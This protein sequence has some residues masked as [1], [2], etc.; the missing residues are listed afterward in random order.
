[1]PGLDEILPLIRLLGLPAT[2]PQ[3]QA[4]AEQNRAMYEGAGL[5]PQQAQT[6]FPDALFHGHVPGTGLPVLGGILRGVGQTGQLLQYI[7]GDAPTAPRP[8]EQLSQM[9]LINNMQR[10]AR[11]DKA[12]QDFEEKH[13]E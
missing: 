9:M 5:T 7:L 1:M 6:A 4:Q 13:P 8:T 10:R 11:Q 3:Q 12:R 2:L